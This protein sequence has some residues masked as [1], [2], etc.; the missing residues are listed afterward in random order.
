M[1]LEVPKHLNVVGDLFGEL[2]IDLNWIFESKKVKVNIVGPRLSG[3]SVF[4]VQKLCR[5][6]LLRFCFHGH[7]QDC[8]RCEG[9]I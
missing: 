8:A 6:S 3:T 9:F 2:A 7:R 1:I 4:D 5:Y